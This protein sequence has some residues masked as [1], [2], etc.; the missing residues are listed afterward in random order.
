MTALLALLDGISPWWWVAAALLIAAAELLTFSYYMLWLSLA[1]FAVAG[2]LTVRPETSG[3]T[4][5][6]VFA[7]LAVVF[8]AIGWAV[9]KRRRRDQEPSTLNSRA[10]AMVG[11]EAVVAEAFRAGVGPV[12][13]DGIRWRGRVVGEG[14]APAPGDALTVVG[15]EGMVLLLDRPA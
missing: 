6:V 12:E 5:L 9:A 14:G 10:N 3:T 1:A 8:T 2:L 4:Q 15:T 13:I 11:R 7:V